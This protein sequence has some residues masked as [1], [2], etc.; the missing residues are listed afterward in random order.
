M[1]RGASTCTQDSVSRAAGCPFPR[2]TGWV[3]RAELDAAQE[4]VRHLREA[5]HH[6]CEVAKAL[7]AEAEELVE[8]LRVLVDSQQ[9]KFTDD[10]V[11]H[12]DAAL[13]NWQAKYG[14]KR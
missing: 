14:V 5:H 10:A 1:T 6:A 8:A 7:R 2:P 13:S 12:A 3:P 11:R 4:G 9:I